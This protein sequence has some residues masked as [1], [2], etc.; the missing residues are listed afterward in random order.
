MLQQGKFE[1]LQTRVTN[2]AMPSQVV[3]I[4]RVRQKVRTDLWPAA[5]QLPEKFVKRFPELEQFNRDLE[6]FVEQMRNATEPDP[7]AL[8]DDNS[9]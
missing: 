7:E 1:N 8:Q 3:R 2:M 5:P 6:T 9:C 4:S